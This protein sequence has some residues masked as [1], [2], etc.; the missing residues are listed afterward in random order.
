MKKLLILLFSFFLLSS[1]SVFGQ[2]DLSKVN[3][4][5]LKRLSNSEIISIFS[6]TLEMGYQSY[7]GVTDKYNNYTYSNGDF[8]FETSSH[9]E[10]GKWKVYENQICWKSTLKSNG[11]IDKMF[12]CAL[13]YT[14]FN[15]GEYYFYI[16]GIGVYGKS[17]AIIN[18][19]D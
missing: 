7:R 19:I 18:L 17:T 16:P 15:E 5:D 8:E 4:D 10:S 12:Q 11:I 6:N 3:I 14:D 1:T 13:V 9:T 2:E